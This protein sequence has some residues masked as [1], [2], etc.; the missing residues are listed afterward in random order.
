MGHHNTKR[1][2]I[3][4]NALK[5]RTRKRYI[6]GDPFAQEQ[7]GNSMD[8]KFLLENYSESDGASIVKIALM[9]TF[10]LLIISELLSPIVNNNTITDIINFILFVS[11]FSF[12]GAMGVMSIRDKKIHLFIIPIEGTGAIVLGWF[13][14]LSGF[15][16][17]LW[18][19]SLQILKLINSA[20]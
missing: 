10:A 5:R 12:M 2:R 1:V 8:F 13:L 20:H 19:I 14:A 11:L 17:S 16:I 9:V 6:I 7:G 15:G 4:T 3:D 18:G